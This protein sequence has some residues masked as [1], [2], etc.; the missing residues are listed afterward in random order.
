MKKELSALQLNN[1]WTFMPLPHDKNLVGSKW[2]FRIKGHSDDTIE[3]YKARLVAKG[4]TQEEGYDYNKTFALV[5]KML[6]VCMVLALTAS[7]D[8]PLYQLD[9]DNAFLH[10]DLNK[11]VY[12]TIPPG[13]FTKEK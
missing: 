8:C 9:V 10:G 3:R 1:T 11:E 7:K 4:F 5:V 6:T 13:Y 2:I 12:M